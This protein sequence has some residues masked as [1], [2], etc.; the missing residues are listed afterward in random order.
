M[1]LQN[2]NI[3]E[4]GSISDLGILKGRTA[5]K[6]AHPPFKMQRL[7]RYALAAAGLVSRRTPGPIVGVSAARLM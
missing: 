4:V 2:R 3:Q 6:A 7:I 1:L 5:A